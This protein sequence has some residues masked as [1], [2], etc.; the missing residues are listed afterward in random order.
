MTSNFKSLN[1]SD[2]DLA[3]GGGTGAVAQTPPSRTRPDAIDDDVTPGNQGGGSAAW[4]SMAQN[5]DA[6]A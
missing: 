3:C 4:D 5:T 6:P 1:D 2:L